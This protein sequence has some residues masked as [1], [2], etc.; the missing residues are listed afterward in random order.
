M[1][2]R[3]IVYLA[4]FLKTS[5]HYQNTKHF[6]YTFLV[7]PQSRNKAYFDV[8]MIAMVMISVFL[9]V[10]E[11]DQA[12]NEVHILF[13]KSI[14]VL[15][16]IEY[17][18]RAW[19]Y[20][21]NHQIILDY[22]EK[23]EYLN[24]PFRLRKV[25]GMILIKKIEYMASPLAV[26]DLLAI[27]PSYRPLRVLRIF[28]IFRLFKLFRYINSIKLFTQ[29]L[30]NKRFELYTLAVFLGFLIFIGS[31]A[32]YVL[33]N[34]EKGGKVRDLFDAFYLTV[35]TLS[36][37]GYGDIAPQTT[38]GRLV[39]MFLIFTGLGVLSFFTSI[40]VSAFADKVHDLRENSIYTELRRYDDIIIICGFGRV[41]LHIARQLHKRQQPFVII[42]KDQ[43]CVDAAKRLGY[44][45]IQAD[46]SKNE[47]LMNAGIIRNASA[48][49]CATG[50]DVTNVYITLTG[51]QLNPDIRI[52][53]RVY[54]AENIKKLYQ[55]G[56]NLV[57]DPIETAGM[58]AA[59]YVGQPV[60]FE[61]IL[62]IM[63]E[64]TAFIME[65]ISVQPESSLIGKTIGEIDFERSKLMLIGVISSHPVHQIHKNRYPLQNQH[66]Y[67]NPENFFELQGGDLL[68]I[69]G[70]QLGI[71]YFRYQIE[72]SRLKPRRKR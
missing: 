1:L 26:I 7:D 31:T 11:V 3:L 59:E 58:V 66:F 18:L 50:D 43:T 57:I 36:T 67:F 38:G 13:E 69:L 34:P 64:E 22:Y 2:T 63:R 35:V 27:L 30:S 61:A 25:V 32:I 14:V 41:A 71:E 29:I 39:A 55:A 33:E 20:N 49:L 21:D 6:F 24:I 17:L 56:A 15:F 68:V 65:T 40:I 60:A 42:D 5:Q 54:Q 23:T 12:P 51:R 48:L 53:S 4:Y 16:V 19:L 9:L 10:Y 37:V 70:K 47:V 45:A 46:A 28:L 72:K 52:I 44:L 62:G 8:F